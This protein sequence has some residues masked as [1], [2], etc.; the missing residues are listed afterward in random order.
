MQPFVDR[1]AALR[2]EAEGAARRGDHA[3][4]IAQLE[5]AT[6]ELVRAIRVGGI[7]IPG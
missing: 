6:R 3:G 2:S 1:A 7:Y 4:A 5:L